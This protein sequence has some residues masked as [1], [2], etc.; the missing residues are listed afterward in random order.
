MEIS[1]LLAL[2]TRVKSRITRCLSDAVVSPRHCVKETICGWN[3]QRAPC[4]NAPRP[5]SGRGRTCLAQPVLLLSDLEMGQPSIDCGSRPEGTGTLKFSCELLPTPEQE[6]EE[7][8]HGPAM[9]GLDRFLLRKPGLRRRHHSVAAI[10]RT[11]SQW[12]FG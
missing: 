3:G 10:P 7:Q 12:A 4:F 2:P 6:K 1:K 8:D 5:F 9:H 11:A